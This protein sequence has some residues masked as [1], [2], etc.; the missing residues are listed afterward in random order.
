MTTESSSK[1]WSAQDDAILCRGFHRVPTD[2]VK[3]P[4]TLVDAEYPFLD[5]KV[6]SDVLDRARTLQSAEAQDITVEQ[7]GGEQLRWC[8]WRTRGQRLGSEVA[9]AN[10]PHTGLTRR[11]A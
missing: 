2:G 3:A 11:A 9:R 1:D 7:R 5:T 8:C 10:V 6:E 4:G